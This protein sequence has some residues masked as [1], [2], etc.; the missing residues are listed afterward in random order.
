MKTNKDFDCVEMMR[1]IREQ[2]DETIKD[3]N[4]SEIIE[5]FSSNN[6]EFEK[7]NLFKQEYKDVA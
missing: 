3:M 4:N 1:S 5:Y 6:E 7:E 2:I